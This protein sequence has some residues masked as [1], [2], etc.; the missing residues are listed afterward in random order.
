MQ[1]GLFRVFPFFLLVD[2]ANVIYDNRQICMIERGCK[3]NIFINATQIFMTFA[4]RFISYLF[5]WFGQFIYVKGVEEEI[6]S[7]SSDF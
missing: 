5:I 4:Y 1:I 2:P 3:D 7:S 6:D